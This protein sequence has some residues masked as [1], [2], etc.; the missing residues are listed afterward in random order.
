MKRI[1]QNDDYSALTVADLIAWEQWMRNKKR[2][3]LVAELKAI[4]GDK[5]PPDAWQKVRD[6]VSR[7]RLANLNHADSID[8]S[9]V[10]YLLYLS[11]KKKN[12]SLQPSE[13]GESMSPDELMAAMQ[14]LLGTF[15]LSG[16][17]TADE[18]EK[19]T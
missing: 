8:F 5:L 9:A 17:E 15:A 11:L 3:E 19:K 18:S 7:I 2:D 1:F 14:R 12:P 13:I 4:Y 16:M 10:E 6:E